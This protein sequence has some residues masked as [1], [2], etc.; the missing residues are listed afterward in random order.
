ML[1]LGQQL[2]NTLPVAI[3]KDTFVPYGDLDE[4]SDGPPPLPK[5]TDATETKIDKSLQNVIEALPFLE[6][7]HF[8]FRLQGSNKSGYY[9]CSLAKGFTP[10]RGR[11]EIVDDYLLCGMKLFAGQS[12]FQ[13]CDGEG[14]E[15]HTATAF[16]LR[17]LF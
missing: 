8:G 1:R 4:E 14:D 10:W 13:H 15:Y 3:P 17:I 7:L 5:K 12:L 11:H 9:I 16:Y 2:Y 6:P